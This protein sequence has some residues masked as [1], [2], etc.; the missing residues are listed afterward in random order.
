MTIECK[1]RDINDGDMYGALLTSEQVDFIFRE[2]RPVF[3]TINDGDELELLFR[4][5]ESQ[6]FGSCFCL[7]EIRRNGEVYENVTGENL[8]SRR[9]LIHK[10]NYLKDSAGCFLPGRYSPVGNIPKV[11]NS[12][13]A[14]VKLL[15]YDEIVLKAT[16]SFKGL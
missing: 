14:L 6:K 16:G 11:V 15:A 3:G 4:P 7:I 1:I 2:Q 8:S 13:D 12:G 10:G 9:I 5:T